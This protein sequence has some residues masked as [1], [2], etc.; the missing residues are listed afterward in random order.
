MALDKRFVCEK[1]LQPNSDNVSYRHFIDCGYV[2]TKVID[3]ISREPFGIYIISAAPGYGKTATA[4]ILEAECISARRC[5]PVYI[6]LSAAAKDRVREY[7]FRE[8]KRMFVER[9][10][11]LL[12]YYAGDYVDKLKKSEDYFLDVL[13][14]M[15]C[16]KMCGSLPHALLIIDELTAP[17]ASGPVPKW[18]E[19]ERALAELDHFLR[20]V[21]NAY[22]N[23][24]G[25]VV[26]MGHWPHDAT[27]RITSALMSTMFGGLDRVR[28]GR[29]RPY[30][31]G[32]F[33]PV[34]DSPR[35]FAETVLRAYGLDVSQL[36]LDAYAELA[37]RLPL[38][39][40]NRLLYWLGMG[41]QPSSNA[42]GKL[43]HLVEDELAELLGGKARARG[44]GGERDVLLPDGR[45]VEIKV[46][47]RVDRAE[48][49]RL[50]GEY[51]SRG[52][53]T[54]FISPECNGLPQCVEVK[55]IDG[56]ATVLLSQNLLELDNVQFGVVVEKV[57][58]P[59]ARRIAELVANFVKAE[60]KVEPRGEC[61][62][63][64]QFFEEDC[65]S[66]NRRTRSEWRAK[67]KLLKAL[68]GW[69][70]PK[71]VDE[72]EAIIKRN[73]ERLEKCGIGLEVRGSY[74]VCK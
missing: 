41:V 21:Q 31:D 10:G 55:M 23:P 57:A 13:G 56:L 49:E 17:F 59:V 62:D 8:F 7:L 11:E 33:I 9:G 25:G 35:R 36:V 44:L 32:D 5:I 22:C 42:L 29:V 14:M 39:K 6:Q 19:L 51:K 54:V 2:R 74:I 20:D 69:K 72:V 4:K 18:E 37:A 40:A 47:S 64:L 15:Y 67:S 60:S 50:A 68:N 61:R 63:L 71:D 58:R 43:S 66:L 30:T 53:M 26:L 73:K 48:V 1:I 45:C 34:G 70:Q 52:C 3:D 12:R 46:R 27:N 24:V 16:S 38:R 28:F 65:K